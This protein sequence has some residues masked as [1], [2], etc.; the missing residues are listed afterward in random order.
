MISSLEHALRI[1]M[2][3]HTSTALGKPEAE[4]F[5]Q[6]RSLTAADRTVISAYAALSNVGWAILYGYL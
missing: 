2:R 1:I 6:Q 4:S 3:I 5:H